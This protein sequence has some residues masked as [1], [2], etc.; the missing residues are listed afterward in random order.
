MYM[1]VETRVHHSYTHTN[2]HTH[3]QTHANTSDVYGQQTEKKTKK[4]WKPLQ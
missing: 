3:T 2:K 1:N 4:N